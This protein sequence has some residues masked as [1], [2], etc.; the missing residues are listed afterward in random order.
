LPLDVRELT[1]SMSREALQKKKTNLMASMIIKY[2]IL[3]YLS[4]KL[5][6]KNFFLFFFFLKIFVII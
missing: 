2:N 1:V 4:Q 3:F 5:K 6:I